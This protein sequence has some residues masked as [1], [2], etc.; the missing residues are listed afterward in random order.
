MKISLSTLNSLSVHRRHWEQRLKSAG[1]FWNS[2]PS[3]PRQPPFESRGFPLR[4]SLIIPCKMPILSRGCEGN[5][6]STHGQGLVTAVGEKACSLVLS[7]GTLKQSRPT[8]GHRSPAESCVSQTLRFPSSPGGSPAN[9][10]GVVTALL[11][12]RFD[13]VCGHCGSCNGL[14]FFL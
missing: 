2:A 6:G 9:S 8:V 1:P 11:N 3:H 5:W 7:P 13:F 14:C 12:K 10:S 4:A